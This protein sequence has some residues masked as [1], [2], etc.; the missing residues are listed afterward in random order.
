MQLSVVCVFLF[1]AAVLKTGESIRCYSCVGLAA[2][3]PTACMDP[4]DA[5]NVSTCDTGSACL[6]SVAKRGD[7]VVMTRSCVADISENG[8]HRNSIGGISSD[9]CW[10]KTDLCN[11]AT[12]QRATSTFLVALIMFAALIARRH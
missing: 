7:T 6:K 4:F 11:G 10:C 12:F 8:C 3:S 5:T 1:V 2:I 9:T